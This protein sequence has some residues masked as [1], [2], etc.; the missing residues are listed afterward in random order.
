MKAGTSHWPAHMM[1]RL[2]ISTGIDKDLNQ[3]LLL[4][5]TAAEDVTTAQQPHSGLSIKLHKKVKKVV[6]ELSSASD[7]STYYCVMKPA[8]TGNPT[9]VHCTK[10]PSHNK[11]TFSSGGAAVVLLS[12]INIVSV[13]SVWR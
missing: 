6:L 5:Y 3:F 11:L 4:I 7:S 13:S 9:T 2:A 1:T 8:V 12:Q 10:T